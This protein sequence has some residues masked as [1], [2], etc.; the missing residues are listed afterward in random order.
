MAFVSEIP[1][2]TIR[3]IQ[4]LEEIPNKIRFLV[5]ASPNMES[6]IATLKKFY[7]QVEIDTTESNNFIVTDKDGKQ[8]QLDNKK[9]TNL[10]DVIDIGKEISEIAGSIGGAASGTVVAPGVG[11]VAGAGAG[12]A[13]GAEI[14]ERV[15]QQFGA[16]MLRTNKEW[17]AQRATDFAFGS[18][19]QVAAPLIVKGFKG[20]ITGFGKTGKATSERLAN[21]IDAGVQPSLGQVTQKQ[22]IQTVE[23]V[24]GNVP[25]ASGKIAAVA[26]KA[27]DDLAKKALN[28]AT[29]NIG[30]VIPADE[31]AVGRIINQG[32]KNGVNASDGFVGRFQAKSGVLFG[33]VDKYLKPEQGIKLNNTVT[34]L[35]DIVAPVKGAE[36]T[37]VVFK[38]QFLND[39]LTGL[40]KDLINGKGTL[41]YQA[42]KSIKNKIGN[43]L[44]SFDLV[45][46]VDKAQLKTIYGTLSEDIKIALKGNTKGLNALTRANKYY[47]SGLKRVDDY[48]LPIAKTADPDRI[49]SLLINTGKE[50]S[51]RLN[52]IKKSLTT[53]QY[54]VFLSNVIDR[55][56]RLQ[57][58]QALAGDF[59]EGVGKFSSETFL[60]NY[61]KLSKAAKESLFGGVTKQNVKFTGGKGW[62]S[63]MQKDFDQI[64]NI[65]NF[66]RQSG[67][68]F[69]NPSGTADRIIGQGILLGGG[70]GAFV[71]NPAFALIGL[72]LIIGGSRV[73]AGLMTNPSFIKWLAQGIK[74]GQN[75]GVDGA[76]QHL[77]RLG[78][79]MGN[80]DSETRQFINEYLQMILGQ[81]N[82][83]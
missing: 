45:N 10:G 32:I 25:G 9:E 40:E 48:L 15:G 11:T 14:F 33:E 37:S 71:A 62:T 66:I 73:T 75:K 50:G 63:G 35:R 18:V 79:I 2:E 29:K 43:K 23:L 52:A 56:G 68:T 61:N 3:R 70:A 8:F 74:I 21:Y 44:S 65:S 16:E 22:G 26:Q 31:V 54:N 82:K 36:G 49:A 5:E 72:P 20:A 34:K 30:K 24:L 78:V 6:K 39:I 17:A 1:T 51:S 64:L 47:Q 77:G 55:M 69:R 38:N 59:V 12:M 67:K 53:D 83:N 13:L 7:P 4:S 42:I 41:P 80:A 28:I 60:T 81:E 27:Q 19:G 76:I 58:S 57:A 46:P